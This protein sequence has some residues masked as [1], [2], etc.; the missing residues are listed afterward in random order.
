MYTKIT[1]GFPDFLTLWIDA[2]PPR[3]STRSCNETRPD[4]VITV[5]ILQAKAHQ[6]RN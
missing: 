3:R 5:A 6:R 1:Q 4:F 2:D